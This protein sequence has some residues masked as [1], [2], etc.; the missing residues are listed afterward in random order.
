MALRLLTAAA[1]LGVGAGA[2]GALGAVALSS[3]GHEAAHAETHID[4]NVATS[5][6]PRVRAPELHADDFVHPL[7]AVIGAVEMGDDVFVGPGAAIRGD[8][9]QP[10]HVGRG[11]NVQDGVVIHALETFDDGHVIE[12]NL[13]HVGGRAYAVYVGDDV[14]IAHQAQVHGPAAIGDGTF[15]GMQALVFRAEI[16]E[17][18]VLEPRALVM[19]VK[20]APHRY[21]PAGAVIRT[22]EQAD[23][24][25]KIDASYAFAEIN[26]NVLHVN[27]ALA[28]R[29]A[30]P[31]P[32]RR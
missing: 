6:S 13:V 12:G 5:F 15:V 1:C 3:H 14:S 7:A 32:G 2:A 30:H 28:E 10:I 29:Y 23:A 20:V 11:S 24:L 9:G 16:G 22:Q 21:V 18:C 31:T 17:G 19:G 26:G 27:H 4:S 25:P 8:E